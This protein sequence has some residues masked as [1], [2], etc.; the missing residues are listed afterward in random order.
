ML[1]GTE[2]WGGVS[3]RFGGVVVPKGMGEA[4]EDFDAVGELEVFSVWCIWG[5]AASAN[6]FEEEGE[7][8]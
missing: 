2:V 8:A 1:D 6:I 3:W 5:G 4:L 7:V